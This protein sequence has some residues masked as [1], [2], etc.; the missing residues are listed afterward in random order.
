MPS[1]QT[2]PLELQ[3]DEHKTPIQ[4]MIFRQIREL[5]QAKSRNSEHK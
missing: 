3:I 1:N 4:G 5:F 2:N